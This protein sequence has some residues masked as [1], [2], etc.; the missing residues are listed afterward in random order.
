MMALTY[1]LLFHDSLSRAFKVAITAL[2]A[3]EMIVHTLAGS[4]S[5]IVIFIESCA[6][7]V[8]A[9]NGR[10]RFRR[11]YL[12]L[13]L[14]LAPL[15]IALMVGSFAIS[16]YN[17]ANRQAAGVVSF[18]V[19]EALAMA[20][21]SGVA[22]LASGPA[23]D[24]VLAPMF[25]RVGFFDFSAEIIAHRQEYVSVLNPTAYAESIVD[26]V[27]TPGFDVYDQ[28]KTG[29]ALQFLYREV[30]P[31]SKIAVAELYQSDQLGIFGELYG[32]FGWYSLPLF[33][34]TTYVLKLA[35]LGMR[36]TNPF[37]FAMKRVI[38]LYVFFDLLNSYGMDWVILET[39]GLMAALF[40]YGFFFT[41]IKTSDG[42]PRP[43][44]RIAA[45][46]GS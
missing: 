18:S 8:L 5:A 3:I 37:T 28:P 33:F 35:F 29:N 22:D 17:R 42:V 7:V 16:T 19:T 10:I 40:I 24:I 20:K 14:I 25:A 44:Q 30:G 31:P 34:L 23:R 41:T 32:L 36:S 38:V 11:K 2:L 27:L 15:I 6:M 1:Y 43:P 46:A 26:N 13:S 45:V 39:I 4:R 21:E 9:I 12:V